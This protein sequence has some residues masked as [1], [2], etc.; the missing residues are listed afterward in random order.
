MELCPCLDA[1][2]WNAGQAE[3]LA[4]L[5][6]R[7]VRSFE[8]W[9]WRARDLDELAALC[10]RF[11]LRPV[12]FS[13]NTF[14][15]PLV[16]PEAHSKTLGHLVGSFAVASRFNVRTLVVHVGYTSTTLNREQQWTAAVRALREA[17]TLAAA[18]GVTLVVEPLNSLIDH[19][20]Y[21]LDSLP[22]ACAL[23]REVDHPRVRLLLDVYHMAVMHHDLTDRVADALPL[24]SH[25]HVADV[26]GR[27]EPGSGSLP[28]RQI[29]P[30]LRRG[31]DGPVGLEW[32]PMLPVDEALRRC[33]EELNG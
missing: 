28:W 7:G 26:P 4:H 17:G 18:A 20:G 3:A 16:D 32:W 2:F 9:D 30:A 13:G 8:F 5:A 12:A 19:P 6:A 31:Y 1:V 15:E 23:V 25:V 24:V 27:G 10:A 29:V 11:E 33:G 22:Q 21:F 14:E